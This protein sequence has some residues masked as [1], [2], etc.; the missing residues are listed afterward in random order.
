MPAS[1]PVRAAS[2]YGPA[3]CL[4]WRYPMIAADYA[5]DRANRGSKWMDRGVCIDRI[6]QP[7]R[8]SA[9]WGRGVPEVV[10]AAG[11]AQDGP[12]TAPA[13]VTAGRSC[14]TGLGQG[15]R[16]RRPTSRACRLQRDQ[17]ARPPT[18]A[19]STATT[20]TR[21]R[22]NPLLPRVELRVQANTDPGRALNSFLRHSTRSGRH[23]W[24]RRSTPRP[25]PARRRGGA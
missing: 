13:G 16:V 6:S 10:I 14:R 4:S 1:P 2:R 15:W 17:L 18:A 7:G 22:N 8:C 12:C 11:H 21:T 25:G 19:G 9:R 23:G 20:H 3:A 24:T 5:T